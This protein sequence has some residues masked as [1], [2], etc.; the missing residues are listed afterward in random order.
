MSHVLVTQ[1][2]GLAPLGAGA[3]GEV[4]SAQHAIHG[5][6]AV[7]KIVPFE[8]E[9]DVDW[10]ARSG[11]L[12]AEGQ[13]LKAAEHDRIVRV[14]DVAYSATEDAVFMAMELCS[15]G[16]A[17]KLFEQGPTPI[18]QLRDIINDVTLGLQIVHGRGLLH[19]DI[20]PANILLDQGRAKL[21][22][23]GLVTDALVLGYASAQGYIDHLAPEVFESGYTSPKT[24]I[25][26]LGMTIY[27]LLHGKAFYDL[28]PPARDIITAG[29][30]AQGLP[31]LPHIPKRWRSFVRRLMADDPAARYQTAEQVLTAI[32]KLPIEP[33]WDCAYAI[34]TGT[35]TR[36]KR[37]R[38]IC[39]SWSAHSNRKHEWRAV[40]AP[41]NAGGRERQ[42]GKSDDKLNKSQCWRSLEEFLLKE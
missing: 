1:I 13:R 25:W 18:A 36:L 34:S 2:S 8:G 20:K 7:K 40:S 37:D 9:S 16:S 41:V 14:L 30:F 42:L 10:H 19:R 26:A 21:G 3:F 31:W 17:Q 11:A 39:V 24:D 38:K 33:S 28:L 27:R 29:G 32:A 12:V 35:W 22:D 23:F 5:Q 15:A 6:I 4:F